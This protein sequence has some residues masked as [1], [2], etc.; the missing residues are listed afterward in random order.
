MSKEVAG[1]LV[2]HVLDD[3]VGGAVPCGGSGL[4]GLRDHLVALGGTFDVGPAL[5]GAR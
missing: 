5:A 3:G 1:S 4:C 2:V